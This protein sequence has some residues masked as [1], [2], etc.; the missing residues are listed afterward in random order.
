MALFA[1]SIH[2]MIMIAC[3]YMQQLI[4]YHTCRCS[5]YLQ[6]ILVPQLSNTRPKLISQ[7]FIFSINVS[8]QPLQRSSEEVFSQLYRSHYLPK[9]KRFY[10]Y[11]FLSCVSE[12]CEGRYY[13][14]ELE[15]YHMMMICMAD[16]NVCLI[17]HKVTIEIPRQEMISSNG[18]RAAVHPS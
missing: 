4:T 5:A 6:S 17:P 1:E 9:I 2:F 15:K 18:V 3:I 14:T 7:L 8:L 12:T 13:Y 10:A 11:H 16:K